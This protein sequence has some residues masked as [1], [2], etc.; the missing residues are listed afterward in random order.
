MKK[1]DKIKDYIEYPIYIKA[2]RI[3]YNKASNDWND[4]PIYKL[5]KVRIYGETKGGK[6]YMIDSYGNFKFTC[7]K[8]EIFLNK[9][10]YEEKINK[11][12]RYK[13]TESEKEY[14]L[15]QFK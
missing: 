13:L 12:T 7:N 9:K 6:N 8:N 11:I 10:D 15:K 4:E 1:K 5:Q 3:I 2:K 14:L